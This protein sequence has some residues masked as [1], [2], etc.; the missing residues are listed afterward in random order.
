MDPYKKLTPFKWFCMQNFPF[1]EEDFDAI[2]E[3]QLLCKIV[4]YL[5]KNI[6]KTNELGV[7][8]EELNNWFIN[9]DVQ[10]EID[11]KLNEMAEDGTLAEIINEEIFNELSG[12]V[13]QNTNAIQSLNEKTSKKY[14]FIGDSYGTGDSEVDGTRKS[15]T[16]YVPEFL[17]LS[18]NDYYTNSINGS[19]FVSGTTFKSILQTLAGSISDKN[20]ISDIVVCGGYNDLRATIEAIETNISDFC[21]YAKTTF[22]NAKVKIGHIGWSTKYSRCFSIINTSLRAYK[23]CIKYG[24]EYLNNVEYSHHVYSNFVSDGYHPNA[25]GQIAISKA[26]TEAVLTGSCTVVPDFNFAFMPLTNEITGNSITNVDKFASSQNNETIT[27]TNLKSI[28]VECDNET[29]TANT[30]KDLFSFQN[31]G[32]FNGAVLNGINNINVPVYAVLQNEDTEI[33][34]FVLTFFQEENSAKTICKGKF[35]DTN[36]VT[37]NISAIL[38]NEFEITSNALYC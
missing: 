11:N 24:A 38:I 6:D 9:L 36:G 8:V 32:V 35:I 25:N 37:K 1:I 13:T 26:I 18:Q 31:S 27:L 4:E 15:W 29:F 34:N 23:N 12:Q 16:A 20:S 28:Y 7:K 5:N 22:P 21:T 19:G 33:L 14:I 3:Y 17:G 10:D 2:T 30:Y